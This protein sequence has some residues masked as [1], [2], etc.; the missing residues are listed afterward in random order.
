MCLRSVP[1]HFAEN[2]SNPAKP[3]PMGWVRAFSGAN[4]HAINSLPQRLSIYLRYFA[5]Y[6]DCMSSAPLP[7]PDSISQ[8]AV[9]APIESLIPPIPF[10]QQERTVNIVSFCSSLALH[11][12]VI[13]IG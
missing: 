7:A 12:T 8:P 11:L 1:H 13:I 10:W 4:R 6:D 2:I 5:E 9:P 3:A